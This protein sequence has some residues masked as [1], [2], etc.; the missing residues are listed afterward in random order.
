MSLSPGSRLGPYEIVAA[1]G[2]GG[3]GE[4]YRA[5]DSRLGREVAVKVLPGDLSTDQDRVRRFEQEARSASALDHPNIITIY[6]IGSADSTLYIAMQYVEGKTLRELL[7]SGPLP[8]KKV[9][10]I[11]VQ[12][13]EGLAKAHAA[14]IK[15]TCA[16][17]RSRP[18]PE[19]IQPLPRPGRQSLSAGEMCS[20]GP[21]EPGRERAPRPAAREPQ[22][23]LELRS[24]S[25]RPN[26]RSLRS[27]PRS[28]GGPPALRR[29]SSPPRRSY[30]ARRRDLARED[31]L[32][33][34]EVAEVFSVHPD[35]KDG[36]VH[37]ALFEV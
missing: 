18:R 13:A 27:S 30:E 24:A 10:E 25:T 7:S 4:V 20:W 34:G 3:M 21:E 12:I 1:L 16:S 35:L 22:Q 9:L 29:C 28:P 14:G 11:S 36:G 31:V 6:D 37:I 19:V 8:T 2:A 5:R 26:P 15:T 23:A 33:S 17:G 32:P